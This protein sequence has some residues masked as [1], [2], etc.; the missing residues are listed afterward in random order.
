MAS[1]R[2]VQIGVIGAPHGVRGEV[3]VKSFTE[4]PAAVATYRPLTDKTGARRFE[5]VSFRVLKAEMGVARMSGVSTREAAEALNGVGLFVARDALPVTQDDDDFYHADLIGLR[6]ET[7][8]GTALGEIV[9]V[10][11]F[12][13]DDLLEVRLAGGR[14]TVYLPFTKAVVPMVDLAGG[15]VVV[16]PPEGTLDEPEPEKDAG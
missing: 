12:G 13:S 6:V 2:L 15:R 16:D 9:A 14:R 8:A 1:Q 3:R 7:T 4:D 5:I 10:Q 11:N